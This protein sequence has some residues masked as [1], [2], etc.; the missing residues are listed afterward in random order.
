[1]SQS[2]GQKWASSLNNALLTRWVLDCY[3]RL[4]RAQALD[5]DEI[6]KALMKRHDLTEI[7]NSGN[8]HRFINSLL[9]TAEV[10]S[11]YPVRAVLEEKHTWRH[12]YLEGIMDEGDWSIAPSNHLQNLVI[13]PSP[14]A[15]RQTLFDELEEMEKQGVI[16]KSNYLCAIRSSY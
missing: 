13:T 7:G 6:K 2:P 1:M 14:Y 9:F 12:P 3:G 16:R 5:N 11:F 10:I 15:M 8:W 4:P